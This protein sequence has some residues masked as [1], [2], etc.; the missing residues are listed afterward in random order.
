M[1]LRSILY[2]MAALF[3][4][5][6]CIPKEEVKPEIIVPTD[7]QA[8]FTDGLSF[9]AGEPSQV[10]TKTL[11]FKVTDKWTATISETTKTPSWLSVLPSSGDAGTVVMTVTV[12]PNTEP[13]ARSAKITITSASVS[14]S[15]TVAQEASAPVVIP[16]VSITL[17]KTTMS[18]D[19]GNSETLVATVSPDNATDKTVTWRSSDVAIAGVDQNGKVTAVD[20]GT[21]TI[22]AKAGE[23][24]STCVVTVTLP[25]V[26]VESITLDKTSVT[27]EKGEAMA[28]TA[29]VKPDNATDKTVVWSSSDAAVAKVDQS[30]IVTAVSEGTATIMAK[31][32]E[33]EATCAVTVTIPIIPVESITLDRLSVTI[34]EGQTTTLVATVV[35]D[36]ATDKTILWNSSNI[37]IVTVD[38]GLVTSVSEGTATVTATAGDKSA[39]CTVTVKKQVIAIT[40]VTLDRTTLNLTKGSSE[41]LVATVKP[42]DATD[43]TV[44]WKSSNTNVASVDQTGKVTA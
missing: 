35:P 3:L 6:S 7:S 15:F 29:T 36:D 44:T 23:K 34:E 14:K 12:Q 27:L 20:T 11:T 30:G 25:I 31:A 13:L 4:F 1:K 17:N 43:K 9:N 32:G 37:D 41:S 33:K 42:D 24:E 8:V 39:S 10:Q 18:L 2:A 38:N 21:A 22:T 28:L 5:F 26:P 19:K 16:V 40:S